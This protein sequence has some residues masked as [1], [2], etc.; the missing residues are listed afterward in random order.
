MLILE[1]LLGIKKILSNRRLHT[2]GKVKNILTGVEVDGIVGDWVYVPRHS[3]FEYDSNYN[4]K[5]GSLNENVQQIGETVFGMEI[6][7]HT[8]FE[9]LSSLDYIKNLS[10]FSS[11]FLRLEP[12]SKEAVESLEDIKD[13]Y[14]FGEFPSGIEA[15]VLLTSDIFVNTSSKYLYVAKSDS[16]YT[17]EKGPGPDH[18]LFV[19]ELDYENLHALPCISCNICEFFGATDGY[20]DPDNEDS[21]VCLA[22]DL[23]QPSVH[24]TGD[25]G[26]CPDECPIKRRLANY[27][28]IFTELVKSNL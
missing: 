19:A 28:P 15:V 12:A 3:D 22:V 10:E 26:C 11:E 14:V 2:T 5:I 27:K 1:D 23:G 4:R 20:Y 25:P 18:D 7:S 21:T 9:L 8:R 16:I 13:Y 6:T 17:I 24:N